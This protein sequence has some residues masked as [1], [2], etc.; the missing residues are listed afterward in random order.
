MK[1]DIAHARSVR[2]ALAELLDVVKEAQEA[3][4]SVTLIQ[5][6]NGFGYPRDPM[7][8]LDGIEVSILKQI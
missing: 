5:K 3:G 2:E 1:P 7:V 4:L 6:Q 8:M